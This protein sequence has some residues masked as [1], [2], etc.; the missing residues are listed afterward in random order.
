MPLPPEV[1]YPPAPWDLSGLLWA[2]L[3]CADT[4]VPLP[5]GL[6]PVLGRHGRIVLLVCYREGT[7]R[8][9]EL[10]IGVPAR[11]GVQVGLYVSR[12]WVDDD[13]ALWGGRHIWGLPKQPARFVWKDNTVHVADDDGTIAFYTLGDHPARLP[14]PFLWAPF[15]GCHGDGYVR[16]VARV[17]ARLGCARLRIH[18]RPERSGVAVGQTCLATVGATFRMRI[19]PPRV[20]G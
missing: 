17:Q 4:P 8:Y 12:I 19:P 13:A 6:K 14:V 18:L 2:G 3:F 11:R 10:V 9:N 5:N 16:T 20:E 1:P 15:W 7:L